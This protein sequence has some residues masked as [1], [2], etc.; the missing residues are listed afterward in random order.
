MFI[1]LAN[2]AIARVLQSV[3]TI[4]VPEISYS[5]SLSIFWFLVAF[6]PVL[7][8]KNKYWLRV[9]LQK[10]KQNIKPLI[11]YTA[12]VL[13]GLFV[14]VA[15]GITDSFHG[16]KYPFIFFFVTPVVEELIFRGWLYGYFEERSK[17]SPV[18]ATAILFGL[19]HLQ[20]FGFVPTPFA[21][22]Q[23]VYTFLLGILFGKMREKSGS[24]YMPMAFHIL[25][26]FITL[27]F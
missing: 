1:A 22:F 5:V 13:L 23:V 7:F 25:I 18:V 24:V 16:V 26:N 4:S 8:F 19:H 9:N 10:I 27:K 2:Y 20:Y 14:F 12:F 11:S 15:L 21:I 3:L 6:V 17:Y